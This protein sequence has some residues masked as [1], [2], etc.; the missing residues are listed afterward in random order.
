M[1][2]DLKCLKFDKSVDVGK[3]SCPDPA[4]YCTNRDGCLV[5]RLS[6]EEKRLRGKKAAEGNEEDGR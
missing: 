4:G 1:D 5:N 3:D 6:I 2:A